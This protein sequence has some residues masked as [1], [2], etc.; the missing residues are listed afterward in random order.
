MKHVFLDTNI[1]MDILANRQPFYKSSSEIYKLGLSKKV[2]YY[3]SSNTIVTLHYLLKR[4]IDEDKIRMALD[5]ITDVINIIP[6]DK[7][8]IKKSLKS[9]HKD[10]EDAIQITT[11]QS[12][13]T[14]DCIITR[15]LKDFKFSE[16]NVYTPDEFLNKL[17]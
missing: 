17:T 11:A 7:N 5:E 14:M 6:V 12:I 1:L 2:I 15:D 8:I 3:T 9:S 16:I 10:F 13:N 4:F